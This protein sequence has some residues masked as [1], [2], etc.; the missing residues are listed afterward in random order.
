[1]RFSKLLIYLPASLLA[2]TVP[3]PA[4]PIE[5][6]R[7]SENMSLAADP[8]ASGGEAVAVRV[9]DGDQDETNQWTMLNEPLGP[10]RYRVALKMRMHLP[11]DFDMARLGMKLHLRDGKTEFTSF[12]LNWG[13][14]DGRPGQ[15]TTFTREFTL[16]EPAQ[17]KLFFNYRFAALSPMEK[18]RP[19]QPLKAPTLNDDTVTADDEFTKTFVKSLASEK[20]RPLTAIEDPVVLLDTVEVHR[21][22]DT[23]L[24][25]KVWPEKV[26]VYPGGEANPITVTVR[27]FQAQPATATV[28]LTMQSGLNEASAPQEQQLTV[29]A[30]GTATCRFEWKSGTRE[31]G[32]GAAAEVIVNGKTVHALTDY[33]SVSTPIWKTGLQGSGFLTWYGREHLFPAHVEN[34]RKNYINVEEAFSWQPSSWTDLNP[35]ADQWFTGQGDAHNSRKGLDLW[36]S[37]SHSNGIKLT[38]YNWPTASGANG[39]EWCRRNPWLRA[40]SPVGLGKSYD[41]ESFRLHEITSKRPELWRLRQGNWHV[42]WVNLG[43]LKAVDVGATEIINSAKTFGWDGVRFDYPPSGWGE[44]GA[45]DVHAQFAELGVTDLMKELLPEYYG[46]TTGNWSDAAT[47]V[48]NVR[49]LKHRFAK[50][51]GPNF[52]VSYNFG[53]PDKDIENFDP[54][55][56]LQ[57]F[58]ECC[59]NGG[60]IM[61]EAIRNNR[62]WTPYRQQALKQAG[63][64]RLLGGFHE[65][66]PAEAGAGSFNAYSAIFTFAAGSHPYT[67]Y[68]WGGPMAGRYTAF[69]TRFGEYS[70]DNGFQPIKPDDFTIEEKFLWKPYLRARTTAGKTQTVVQL[71]SPPLN[72]ECA[73]AKGAQCTPWSTGIKVHKRGTAPPTVWRLSAEPNVQCE[74]LEARK[75]GDGFTVTVPEHRLWTLLV[76]EEAQ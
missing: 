28:R 19:V 5:L 45:E 58:V 21:L 30:G 12:D 56:N 57:M 15:F 14:F 49:Y 48:R 34:N 18:K 29:P 40:G 22:N 27:N 3:L 37:L 31:F 65:C 47:S 23:L 66:F 55:K 52:A 42:I 51:L 68:G 74:K 59:R 17:P 46:I 39:F 43:M 26:H 76:W 69:M 75:E 71:I 7:T 4:Q 63:I 32:Y 10:G 73:P 36:M 72:E 70:W 6:G 13:V 50:E 62:S 41:I 53:L 25:E 8:A 64:T 2:A 44:W 38:T 9:A 20:A 11:K 54:R 1:M 33:F 16:L 67:D 60:Q 61:D 24:V 35:T